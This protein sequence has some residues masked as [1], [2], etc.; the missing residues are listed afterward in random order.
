MFVKFLSE[1]CKSVIEIFWDKD[2]VV[3]NTVKMDN[4]D[5]RMFSV[6]NEALFAYVTCVVSYCCSRENETWRQCLE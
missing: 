1:I 4:L 6:E 2:F 3:R 5:V